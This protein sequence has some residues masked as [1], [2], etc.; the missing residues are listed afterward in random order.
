MNK[1]KTEEVKKHL[2]KYGWKYNFSEP[3]NFETGWSTKK[4]KFRMLISTNNSFTSFTVYI[5]SLHKESHELEYELLRKLND[6][7]DRIY[8]AKTC[9][10]SNKE[11]ILCCDLFNRNKINYSNFK[12]TLSLITYYTHY[13]YKEINTIVASPNK[14]PYLI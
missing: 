1:E 10:T 6:F 9:L 12:L 5:S 8:F 2:I 3:N 7:N 14:A 11:I 4:E 13:F